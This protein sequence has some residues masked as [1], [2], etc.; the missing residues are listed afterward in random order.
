MA[1][2]G[3]NPELQSLRG[4]SQTSLMT[5]I[6]NKSLSVFVWG[7]QLLL[8]GQGFFIVRSQ[9]SHFFYSFLLQTPQ[10]TPYVSI[11]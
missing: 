8:L 9:K 5:V 6:I 3:L 11:S 7:F 10:N 1:I 4:L 2:I